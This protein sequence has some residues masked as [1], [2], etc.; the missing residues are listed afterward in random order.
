MDSRPVIDQLRL[1]GFQKLNRIVSKDGVIDKQFLKR[2]VVI[3][4]SDGI[5]NGLSIDVASDFLKPVLS[6][7]VIVA[8]PLCNPE[9][10]DRIRIMADDLIYLNIVEPG[11]PLSHYYQENTLPDHDEV[12][13]MMSNIS[14]SW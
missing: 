8:T 10:V 11:F 4:V 7:Q 13:K 1:E 2:H 5:A 9:I 6:E 3:I 12:I 14:L